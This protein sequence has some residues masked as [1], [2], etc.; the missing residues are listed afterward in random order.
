MRPILFAVISLV[1][2]AGCSEPD[3]VENTAVI[4]PDLPLVGASSCKEDVFAGLVGRPLSVLDTIEIP[5]K[6]RVIAPG[7]IVTTEY[8]PARLNVEHSE[9]DVITRAWCG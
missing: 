4:D 2:L 8:L 9:R 5:E 1:L 7:A 6:T 3:A